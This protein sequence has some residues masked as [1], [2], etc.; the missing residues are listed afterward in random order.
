[1]TK[2]TLNIPDSEVEFFMKLV[3]KFNYEA[4][5]SVDYTISEDNKKLVDYRNQTAKQTDYLTV[6]ESNEKL[7][8]KYGF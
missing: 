5:Q 3:E 7:K 2:I 8:N 4:T 1:M 6:A